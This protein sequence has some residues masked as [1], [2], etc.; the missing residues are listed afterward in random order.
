[1]VT[2]ALEFVGP[3]SGE[4]VSEED[5][6]SFRDDICTEGS[7]ISVSRSFDQSEKVLRIGHENIRFGGSFSRRSFYFKHFP[8]KIGIH[9]KA[10]HSKMNNIYL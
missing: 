5:L 9:I 1:M 10:I 3:S 6:N 2:E 4:E 8:D 7:I